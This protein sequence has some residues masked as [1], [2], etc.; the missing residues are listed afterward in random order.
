MDLGVLKGQVYSRAN[1]VN[2]LGQVVGFSG[3]EARQPREPRLCVD[4]AKPA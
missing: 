2:A 3:P 1:G 4:T